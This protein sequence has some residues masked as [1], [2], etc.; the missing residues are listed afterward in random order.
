MKLIFL[1]YKAWL[2]QSRD[3]LSLGILVLTT[4]V[5]FLMYYSLTNGE[6]NSFLPIL[7]LLSVIM[8]VFSSSLVVAKEI[9]SKTIIRMLLAGIPYYLVILGLCMVQF[10]LSILSIVFTL[11][12]FYKFD[13]YSFSILTKIFYSACLTSLCCIWIGASIG[14]LAK[15]TLKA[16]SISSLIMFILLILSGAMFP[17]PQVEITFSYYS[18]VNLFDFIPSLIFIKSIQSITSV[19]NNYLGLMVSNT[20]NCLFY[21]FL[22]IAIFQFSN[23]KK[24]NDVP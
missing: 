7:I 2:Q 16:F 19:N 8:V 12:L 22:A 15:N 9:E 10:L 21:L 13:I 24:V 14:S 23:F 18:Q 1:I 17:I 20:I 6:S 3:I 5:L 4:P 11:F